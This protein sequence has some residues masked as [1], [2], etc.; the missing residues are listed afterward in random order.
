M[1]LKLIY[2]EDKGYFIT[3]GINEKDVTDQIKG[4]ALFERAEKIEKSRKAKMRKIS[5]K[6]VSKNTKYNSYF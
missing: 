4:I 5:K 1:N 6:G 2:K 3:D